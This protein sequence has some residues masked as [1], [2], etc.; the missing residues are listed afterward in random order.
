MA[1]PLLHTTFGLTTFGLT[2]LGLTTV[3][4]T[5]FGT[6]AAA[7]AAA[8]PPRPHV[9]VLQV[10][11]LIDPV[12]ADA[13]SHALDKANTGKAVALV[14][15][16][17]SGGGVLSQSRLDALTAK[18]A[19]A[20]VPVAVWVGPTG[21]KAKGQAVDLV[22]AA[23]L[24]GVAPGAHVPPGLTQIAAPT[25][26]DFVVEL[27]GRQVGD[28]TLHTAT[29][30]QR[31]GQPRREL[32]V[33]VRNA[34]PGLLAL[35]LHTAAS[36]SVACLLLV[37]GLALLVLEFFTAGIGIA[38]VTGA[39]A[40]V[41]SGYGLAVLPT[42]WWAVA[43]VVLGI[44]GYAV[45]LQAGT[46]RT[47]TV[48]GTLALAV[49]TVTLFDGYRASWFTLVFVV[50]GTALFMVAGMPAMVRARFSTPTIG[51]ESMV[52]ELGTALADVDPEGTVEVRGA[53]WRART[54]R[55]TPITAGDS[56]RVVA[57]DGLLLEVEPE[58]GGARD[59]RR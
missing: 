51:R 32:T 9:D 7:A 47:W 12:L 33:E 14:L 45:D 56:V 21:A 46:P 48:I 39:G 25:I 38:A 3:G 11:G 54:N 59:Y 24:R 6:T 13:I 44:F 20:T 19:H 10:S 15:Q 8:A 52:G 36:P 17:N 29:V 4:L 30:V 42:N 34:K 27:D 53:P 55:A 37:V 41:L 23:P 43:L 18:L 49:G 26:G 16:L 35:L 50:A 5:T 31:N 22:R 1:V 58:E 28:Q 40:L 57:I 2:T